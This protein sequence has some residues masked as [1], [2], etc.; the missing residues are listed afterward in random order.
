MNRFALF[1]T[2]LVLS[3]LVIF[4]SCD[5]DEEDYNIEKLLKTITY[6]SDDKQFKYDQYKFE[7]DEQNRITKISELFYE[8]NISYTQTF[9]YEKDDLV[10]V[11]FSHSSGS[12]ETYEYTKSGNTISQKYSWNSDGVVSEGYIIPNYTTTHTIELNSDGLPI[13]R[14]R[15][16]EEP[17]NTYVETFEYQDGNLTK[18]TGIYTSIGWDFTEQETYTYSYDDKKGTLYYCKTPKWYLILRLNDLGINN[19]ITKGGLG[20]SWTVYTYKYDKAGFPAE[21]TRNWSGQ[22][23][24]SRNDELFTYIKK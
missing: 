22:M 4:T 9:T 15:V 20:R 11:L 6:V 5:K 23:A 16:N 8:G 13:K 24:T 17:G 10:Q 3:A 7:Y 2:V 18:R 1:N 14:E 19:N 12:I 21:R